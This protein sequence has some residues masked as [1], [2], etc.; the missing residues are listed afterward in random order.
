MSTTSTP[1]ASLSVRELE[2]LGD[3]IDAVALTV[4]GTGHLAG[5]L[6]EVEAEITRRALGA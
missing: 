3:A 6:V 4:P 5:T 2:A 1:F